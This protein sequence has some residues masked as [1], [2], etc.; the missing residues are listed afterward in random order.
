M[1]AGDVSGLL[2]RDLRDFLLS[3]VAITDL[4]G[5]KVH[6][7]RMPQPA[8]F[9]AIVTS[10]ITTRPVVSH[11]GYSELRFRRVQLD[12]YSDDFDELLALGEAVFRTLEGFSG[13]MGLTQVG[14]CFLLSERDLDED[15]LEGA[16]PLFRRSQDWE[17]AEG[18]LHS[19][20]P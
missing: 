13:N 7:M 19:T 14:H 12:L 9:P 6:A 11:D 18:T 20:A 4:V 1:A 3:R 17:F 5:E 2:Q 16:K 15:G 10:L 8:A